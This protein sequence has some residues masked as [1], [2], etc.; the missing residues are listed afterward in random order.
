VSMQHIGTHHRCLI[1]IHLLDMDCTAT[2]HYGSSVRSYVVQPILSLSWCSFI[3]W[4]RTTGSLKG[5]LSFGF[6]TRDSFSTTTRIMN[7]VILILKPSQRLGLAAKHLCS[8]IFVFIYICQVV[9]YNDYSSKI[10]WWYLDHRLM[11]H[12]G[13]TIFH[14]SR[15]SCQWSMV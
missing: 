10:S 7:L 4:T 15:I 5:W 2:V 3:E 11:Q 12:Q 8:D 1:V 13:S 6:C 14:S 9:R